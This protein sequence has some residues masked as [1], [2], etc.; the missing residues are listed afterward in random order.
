MPKNAKEASK[1]E[2]EKKIIQLST[3][4]MAYEAWV[5]KRHLLHKYQDYAGQRIGKNVSD[6][7]S[8]GKSSQA[9]FPKLD[10]K[11]RIIKQ[12]DGRAMKTLQDIAK[13]R[14]GIIFCHR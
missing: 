12:R 11:D 3:P 4:P 10:E 7:S 13:T 5:L 9:F 14:N 8:F 6:A 1:D 2:T